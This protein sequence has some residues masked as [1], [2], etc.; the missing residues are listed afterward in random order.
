[1]IAV[2]RDNEDA[3]WLTAISSINITNQLI[4]YLYMNKGDAPPQYT[5]LRA[6]RSQFKAFCRMSVI[7]KRTFF[8]LNFFGLRYLHKSWMNLLK[9]GKPIP[10]LMG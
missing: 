7:S 3:L 2:T 6:G 10:E 5:K 8:E 4:I 9:T 1:M